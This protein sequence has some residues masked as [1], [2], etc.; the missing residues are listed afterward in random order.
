MF[1]LYMPFDSTVTRRAQIISLLS[2]EMLFTKWDLQVQG[3]RSH[4]V[5]SLLEFLPLRYWGPGYMDLNRTSVGSINFGRLGCSCFYPSNVHKR[6]LCFERIADPLSISSKNP[7]RP[8]KIRRVG[9]LYLN[10]GGT[11]LYL[12]LSSSSSVLNPMTGSLQNLR[13]FRDRNQE[14]SHGS[15]SPRLT[16][17]Y[18]PEEEMRA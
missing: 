12:A 16:W 8:C 14:T 1:G 17:I 2:A 10:T 7:H 13:Y 18:T 3:K 4:I 11:L 15:I 6:K 9:E 5:W